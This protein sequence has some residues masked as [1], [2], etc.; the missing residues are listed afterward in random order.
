MLTASPLARA[1]ALLAAL[2]LAAPVA[3]GLVL[4]DERRRERVLGR[5][6]DPWPWAEPG[7]DAPRRLTRAL[8]DRALGVATAAAAL[9]RL[10]YEALGDDGVVP[11][12]RN[13]PLAFVTDHNL[14][15][16]RDFNAI[17]ASCT[18]DVPG[19]VWPAATRHRAGRIAAAAGAPARAVLFLAV[20]SKP[21]LYADR[22]PASVPAALREDCRAA[23][24]GWAEAW[25]AAAARRGYRVAY[26]LAAFRAMRDRPHFYPP[27]NFHADGAAADLAARAALAALYP[28]EPRPAPRYAERPGRADMRAFYLYDRRITRLE[29]V[30]V[31]RP[32][33]D[34]AAEA[35][36]AARF[37]GMPAVTAWRTADAPERDALVVGNSFAVRIA[38]HLAR[39]FRR[40]TLVEANRLGPKTAS[41]LFDEVIPALE[42]DAV[43]FV[44]HDAALK[45]RG[46]DDLL[47]GARQAGG[48][49]R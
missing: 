11:V 49:P 2:L 6:L 35:R 40:L 29:P 30:G 9:A 47:A 10:R 22:L 48:P 32:A 16:R 21:V 33:R 18:P 38:P 15:G 8:A 23:G 36:L 28:D 41:T 26:P 5:G 13:A 43:I 1:L 17:R 31:P 7:P 4:L 27:E 42:P 37:P 20:P 44:H 34:G 19:A 46:L 12:V 24:E 3:A 39:G 45:T 14:L 25:A